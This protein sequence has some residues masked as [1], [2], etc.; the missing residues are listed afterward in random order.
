[1]SHSHCH[2]HNHSHNHAHSHTHAHGHSGKTLIIR[3]LLCIIL[4]AIALF[5]NQTLIF[6]A[7]YLTIGFDV[8]INAFKN[9]KN[10]LIFDEN[11]LMTIASAGAFI[12]GEYPESVAVMLFYQVGEVLQHNAVDNSEREISKLINILPNK[13]TLLTPDGEKDVKPEEVNAGEII[14]V[15]P[16]ERIPLDGI[17][18]K[19]KS[20]LNTAEITGESLPATVKPD[21]DIYSGSIVLSG[22]LEI[23]VTKPYTESTVNKIYELLE[24]AKERKAKVENFI[25]TF[26]IFY[27]PIVVGLAIAIAVLPPLYIGNYDFETWVYRGLIFLVCSCP[28]ALVIS[29]PLSF[30]ISLG[31]ASKQ[32]ILVKGGNYL[33]AASKVKTIVFDKTGTLT[34][35]KPSIVKKI[36]A[37]STTE[38]NLL[39]IAASL[40]KYSLHPIAKAIKHDKTYEV[41][42]FR[43][44]S[45]KGITGLIKGE[46]ACV[47]NLALMKE[48]DIFVPDEFTQ[49]G[50]NVH[51][52]YKGKYLGFLTIGDKLKENAKESIKNLNNY[53]VVML[54]GDNKDVAEEIGKTLG[55]KVF[56]ELLPHQKV[57]KT[58]ALKSDGIL[59]AVGDGL[60]DAPMLALS[61]IGVAMGSLGVEASIE[62]S[63]V[64]LMT[65]DLG[66]IYELIKIAKKTKTIV[67]QN[68]IFALGIKALV[69]I[70][71]TV[72]VATMWQ[73]VF[74]D[75]GVALIA[76]LNSLRLKH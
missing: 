5:I 19:G 7:A 46:K 50:T 15:R 26:A 16:G 56:S 39:E 58:E 66:K 40:E 28:C 27:T 55:I 49:E 11:F 76:I 67:M 53:N 6:A 2:C 3:I 69:M 62:A 73:A 74:A 32:G 59:M 31:Y 9:L 63:D 17:V 72:G 10:R 30:F 23:K 25:T 65:D 57:E 12:I 4:F 70:L 61:D 42:N 18:L 36:T 34:A 48:N 41:D 24:S 29:V 52:A 13:A 35:G 71:A 22:V 68:I 51:V 47:G 37:P 8:M 14:I 45:G 21:E 75:I 1:M 20:N 33:E 64:V 44:I 38:N 60:N 43:E 54:S